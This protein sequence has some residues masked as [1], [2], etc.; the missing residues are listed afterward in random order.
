MKATTTTVSNSVGVIVY[1]A[2]TAQQGITIFDITDLT[3]VRY[4]F[5]D[6]MGMESE[7]QVQLM[8]PLS[9][10]TYLEAY[11][12]LDEAED[13]ADLK[14]LLKS[15]EGKDLVLTAALEDA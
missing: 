10:R 13:R 15:F 5:V 7:R 8:T 2:N 1:S 14:P 6:F 11:Y 9:A 4:C 12:V 3:K